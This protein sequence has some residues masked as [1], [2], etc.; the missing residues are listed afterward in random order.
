MRAAFASI[1]LFSFF[2][3]VPETTGLPLPSPPHTHTTA[4]LAV[5]GCGCTPRR[6]PGKAGAPPS[7]RQSLAPRQEVDAISSAGWGR[8]ALGRSSSCE[9]KGTSSAIQAHQGQGQVSP[10]LLSF[11]C[12]SPRDLGHLTCWHRAP[13]S[14]PVK[15]EPSIPALLYRITGLNERPCSACVPIPPAI[16]NCSTGATNSSVNPNSN[17]CF[18]NTSEASAPGLLSPTVMIIQHN[19]NTKSCCS[20]SAHS[21]PSSASQAVAMVNG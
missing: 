18:V 11:C 14:T 1:K 8:G 12:N 20:P 15:W 9:S 7:E 10:S 17:S 16:T 2:Q 3:M 13:V 21:M 6:G 5:W 19:G 4:T